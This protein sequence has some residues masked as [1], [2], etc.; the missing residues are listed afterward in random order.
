MDAVQN[1][2]GRHPAIGVGRPEIDEGAGPKA[3]PLRSCE[4]D[5]APEQG[6]L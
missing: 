5:Q 6:A 2:N 4:F 3:R 1:F